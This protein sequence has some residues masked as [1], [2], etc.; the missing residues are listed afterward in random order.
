MR[1][2]SV[3]SGC[4]SPPSGLD[5]NAFL[6]GLKR[7]P[8][9]HT[10]ATPPATSGRNAARGMSYFFALNI[11]STKPWIG[12]LRWMLPGTWGTTKLEHSRSECRSLYF[13]NDFAVYLGVATPRSGR[14]PRDTALG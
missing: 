9:R 10:E 4:S 6:A 7:P 8:T 2:S 5:T 13:T 1:R 11:D 12:L 14:I 3:V